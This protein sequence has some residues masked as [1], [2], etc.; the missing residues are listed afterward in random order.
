L[1]RVAGIYLLHDLLDM[2][3]ESGLHQMSV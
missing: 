3:I 2:V 1:L